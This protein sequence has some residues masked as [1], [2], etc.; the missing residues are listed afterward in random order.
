MK[1]TYITPEISVVRT[2]QVLPIAASLTISSE[3]INGV[4]GDVKVRGDW[5]IFDYGDDEE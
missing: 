2:E 5:E 1:Q 4:E 3:P